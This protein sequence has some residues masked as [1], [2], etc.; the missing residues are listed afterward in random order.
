MGVNAASPHSSALHGDD[1]AA[2][3]L[4][5]RF[6]RRISYLRLSLTEHCNFRCQYCS[7]ATGT[8]FFEHQ[9][10]LRP[11]ELQRILQVFHGLGLQHLRFTGGEPLIHPHLLA[12]VDFARQ[13][14]IGKISLS[15]N[16]YLLDRLAAKLA[17]AGL[18]S[19]NI[20]LD[21]LEEKLF[22]QVTRGGDL[23]RVLRGIDAAIEHAIPRIKLNVVLLQQVNADAL[24]QL[25][26]FAQQ[27]GLD[28]RFIETMPL[29][30]AGTDSQDRDYLSAASARERV[31]AHFGMLLPVA[32]SRDQGPARLYALPGGTGRIGFISPISENFC[33]T[34]N[35]VRL[36]ATG[37]LVY[38]LGQEQG[39]ELRPLLRTA[40]ASDADLLRAIR[41]GVWHDKPER[42]EFDRDRQRSSKIF[43]MRLGG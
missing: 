20:S 32:S 17:H 23:K 27:R 33:A 22:T 3:G 41:A 12:H 15:S 28:I 39:L 43:M 31:E 38:C 9:D 21:T 24:P 40:E 4:W 8:P 13:L 16:G 36:T 14:G 37:R 26:E 34:C 11:D 30:S 6:G 2:A 29:G 10:H 42:H 18:N 19:I 1:R 25:V 5:D 7:P 35:R